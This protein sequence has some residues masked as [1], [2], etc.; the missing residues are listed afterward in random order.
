MKKVSDKLIIKQ[1]NNSLEL[2]QTGQDFTFIEKSISD[3]ISDAYVCVDT[4]KFCAIFDEEKSKLDFKDD[5][6]EIKTG[7]SK[8]LLPYMKEYGVFTT[9]KELEV[10]GEVNDS[11][12]ADYSDIDLDLSDATDQFSYILFNRDFVCRYLYN[13]M[14]FYSSI[15][16]VWYNITPKQFKILKSMGKVNIEIYE[17]TY[18]KASNTE[19]ILI[20]RLYSSV[21]NLNTI[22]KFF[23]QEP[24]SSFCLEDIDYKKLKI[25]LKD[26]DVFNL[27]KT[28]DCL[29]FAIDSYS[30]DVKINNIKIESDFNIFLFK[31]DL[32]NL[33]GNIKFYSISGIK[34]IISNPADYKTVLFTCER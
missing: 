6:L 16:E 2:I 18:L 19:N 15:P 29:T 10:S 24:I 23:N 4:T 22:K 27:I 5:Y 8:G 9:N 20:L 21:I 34:Y 14:S 3:N 11:F 13:T 12:E 26:Y 1:L 32:E 7:R 31:K 33:V 25:F 17:N 28:D 30:E